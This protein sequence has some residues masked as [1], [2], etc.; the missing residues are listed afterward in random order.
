[1]HDEAVARAVDV[2]GGD[3]DQPA[4]AFR[5]ALEG[6]AVHHQRIVAHRAELQL[7]RHHA[8][9]DGRAGGEVV[10]LE[11][12]LDVGVLAVLRQI[13]LQQIELADDRRRW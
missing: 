9:G 5:I 11:F 4:L 1:M 6:E 13:L 10:P 2:V 7:V 8:V 12:E 3:R